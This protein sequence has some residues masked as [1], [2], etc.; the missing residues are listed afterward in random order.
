[1]YMRQRDLHKMLHKINISYIF[2]YVN[3]NIFNN[4][5]L[6]NALRCSDRQSDTANKNPSF[7]IDSAPVQNRS[8][9]KPKMKKIFV[10]NGIEINVPFQLHAI[11]CIN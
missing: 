9:L 3:V 10:Q 2:W 1:M 4:I 6:P 5:A 8:R 11:S 7:F